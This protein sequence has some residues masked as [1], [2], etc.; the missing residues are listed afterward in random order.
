MALNHTLFRIIG[1]GWLG[2]IAVG[3]VVS[4]VFAV[5]TVALLI[6]RS[7]CGPFQ[8]RKVS[9]AYEEI[10]TQYQRDRVK[11]SQILL[12]S[13]LGEEVVEVP[14]TPAE[15]RRLRTY[16]QASSERLSQLEQSYPAVEVLSCARE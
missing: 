15:F 11:F 6:D 14:L 1:C 7:Y 4:R 12:I 10:Y 2:F 16:G 3:V 8:W 13:D 5:P 9:E